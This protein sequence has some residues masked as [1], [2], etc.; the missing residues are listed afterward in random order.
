MTVTE[1][2]MIPDLPVEIATPSEVVFPLINETKVFHCIKPVASIYPA[3][4]AKNIANLSCIL[5]ESDEKE[6]F[7]LMTELSII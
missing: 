5:I 2:I 4:K 7:V 1:V 6:G 3:I